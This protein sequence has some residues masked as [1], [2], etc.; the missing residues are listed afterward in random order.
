MDS[1]VKDFC[2][3]T[4]TLLYL[5]LRDKKGWLSDAELDFFLDVNKRSYQHNKKGGNDYE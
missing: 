4:D 2:D 5:M 3:K 1:S